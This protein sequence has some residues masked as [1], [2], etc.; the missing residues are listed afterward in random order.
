MRKR[1]DAIKLG[2][3]APRQSAGREEIGRKRQEA[4]SIGELAGSL[5]RDVI[6]KRGK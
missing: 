6:R 1:Q 2:S 3:E 5:M 4:V